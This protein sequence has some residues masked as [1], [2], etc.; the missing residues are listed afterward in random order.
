MLLH[1]LKKYRKSSSQ[2]EVKETRFILLLK[3]TNKTKQKPTHKIIIFKSLNMGPQRGVIPERHK[4]KD[5][6]PASAKVAAGESFQED[7]RQ[8]PGVST[9]SLC[10]KGSGSLGR[11]RRLNSTRQSI[12]EDEGAQREFQ[13][14][15]EDSL[16]SQVLI[17]ACLGA[18]YLRSGKESFERLRGTMSQARN[19]FCL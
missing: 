1:F 18:N 6:S 12:K 10:W 9:A 3:S 17:R 11:P 16:F 2:N 7:P 4:S 8:K 5:V 14:S 19:T 13:T 15:T